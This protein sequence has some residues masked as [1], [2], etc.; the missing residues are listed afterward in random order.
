MNIGQSQANYLKTV[1]LESIGQDK[2]GGAPVKLAEVEQS[3]RDLAVLFKTTAEHELDVKNAIDTNQL[4]ESIQFDEVE[5]MGGVYS[6]D[7]SVLDYYKFVNKGVK[8]LNNGINGA[9]SPF[10]FKNIGVSK[11][12]MISIRKWVIRHALKARVKPAKTHPLGAEKKAVFKDTSNAMAYAIATSIKKKG[13]KA[14]NFWDK[15]E[16]TTQEQVE[17]TLGNAF[18]ISIVN[19]IVK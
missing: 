8:G 14:T 19:E 13:L 16:Q 2:T 7:I 9:Q 5:F 11:A 10:S 1:H 6:I 15:A 12:F 4:A 18:A 17:K 3:L